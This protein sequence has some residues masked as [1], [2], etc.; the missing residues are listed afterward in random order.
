MPG[1]GSNCARGW[2]QAVWVPGG[3]GSN[4]FGGSGKN[5]DGTNYGVVNTIAPAFGCPE[6]ILVA[7]GYL[8][9]VDVFRCPAFDLN[10]Y[11]FGSFPYPY[12]FEYGLA[13]SCVYPATGAPGNPGFYQ[14]GVTGTYDSTNWSTVTS[15]DPSNLLNYTVADLSAS[16][17]KPAGN[18]L[19]QTHHAT[20]TVYIADQGYGYDFDYEWF[21]ASPYTSANHLC[22]VAVNAPHAR[23]TRTNACYL[24]GHVENLPAPV[25]QKSPTQA[26]NAITSRYFPY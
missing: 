3:T 1:S 23:G 22:Y 2:G 16:P 17:A 11:A 13:A 26:F 19:T 5:P 20:E 4:N 9:S 6:S 8:K 18:R 24:D 10:S 21:G 15:G 7:G 14:A 12:T 25:I